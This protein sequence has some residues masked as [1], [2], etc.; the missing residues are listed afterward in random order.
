MKQKPPSA[1]I[2]SQ[3]LSQRKSLISQAR[4]GTKSEKRSATQKLMATGLL[5]RAHN[6][7]G[8]GLYKTP[9][10]SKLGVIRL[11]IAMVGFGLFVLWAFNA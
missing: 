9:Q 8:I 3:K 11:S 6:G 7:S 2:Y 1:Q 5:T 4:S 10:R